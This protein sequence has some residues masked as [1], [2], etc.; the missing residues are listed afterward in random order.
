MPTTKP[1]DLYLL[2]HPERW[3]TNDAYVICGDRQVLDDLLEIPTGFD[4]AYGKN[5]LS[6]ATQAKKSIS[7]LDPFDVEYLIEE[8][9]SA[10]LVEEDTLWPETKGVPSTLLTASHEKGGEQLQ[11]TEGVPIGTFSELLEADPLGLAKAVAHLTPPRPGAKVLLGGFSRFDC[12]KRVATK[13]QKMG[14]DVE[15]CAETALPLQEDGDR[16]SVV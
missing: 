7:I 13:M 14:W 15:I 1:I 2:V 3:P 5:V 4:N 12:V 6:K 16:K 8:A 9:E 11:A 10:G